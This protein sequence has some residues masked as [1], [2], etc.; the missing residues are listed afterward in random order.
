MLQQHDTVLWRG[1]GQGHG[2]L[3]GVLWN[4]TNTVGIQACVKRDTQSPV[5]L[6][7]G[8]THAS[9]ISINSPS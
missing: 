9:G 7:G 8:F 6:A 4:A 1:I 5:V 2:K 3:R